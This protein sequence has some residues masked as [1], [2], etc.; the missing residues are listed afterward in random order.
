MS[1]QGS[2][3]KYGLYMYIKNTTMSLLNQPKICQS[4][5]IFSAVFQI[6]YCSKQFLSLL[7]HKQMLHFLQL[8]K[9]NPVLHFKR[10]CRFSLHFGIWSTPSLRVS[11]LGFPCT[12]ETFDGGCP[13]CCIH[14][15]VCNLYQKCF[16]LYKLFIW[17]RD[18]QVTVM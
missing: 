4:T 3:K 8:T 14:K 12:Q 1:K 10:L 5:C 7:K 13:F 9:E 16:E 2:C 17:L 15:A 18:S 6:W 11:R